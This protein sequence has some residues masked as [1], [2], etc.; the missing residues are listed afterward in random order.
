M[1]LP[2]N[3]PQSSI[4][5]AWDLGRVNA[6]EAAIDLAR[7][8]VPFKSIKW[9][10]QF[11]IHAKAAIDAYKNQMQVAGLEACLAA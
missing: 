3:N 8:G 6:V 1:F 5:T 9:S 7:K 11:G 4:D 2:L 10:K